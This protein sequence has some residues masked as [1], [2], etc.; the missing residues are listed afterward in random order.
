MSCLPVCAELGKGASLSVL[1]PD[2]GR[3]GRRTRRGNGNRLTALP[4]ELAGLLRGGLELGLA[5]NPLQGPILQLYGHG[6]QALASYLH[7]LE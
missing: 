6:P 7:G 5:G 2:T 4:Q 3:R 1:P